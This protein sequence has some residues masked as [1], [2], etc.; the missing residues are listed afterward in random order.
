VKHEPQSAF[1]KSCISQR[2][3]FSRTQLRLSEFN[4][5]RFTPGLGEAPRDDAA[6]LSE[7][8]SFVA[9]A[10]ARIAP[11]LGGLPHDP[12]LFLSWF[13]ELKHSGPGQN[14]LLFP[15]LA[16]KADWDQMRW[17]LA[18]ELAGEAGFDDLVA[19]TQIKMPSRAKLEMARNYWDEMG[20]GTEQGMHGPM[21]S[22]LAACFGIEPVPD[23]TVPESLAL[24]NMMVGLAANRRY[25]FHAV[26][27]L[28]AIELTAPTRAGFVAAGL[29]RL[30]VSAKARNYFALHAVLDVKHA[31]AW[32]REVIFSLVAEDPRRAPA[33]AEGAL[34]RL[35]CGARCFAR[36][37]MQFGR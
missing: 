20:R 7:E 22:R 4:R 8:E 2:T 6:F 10:R 9:S 37:R 32:N 27:A 31:E 11:F 29:K 33:I 1:G 26:G 13:E 5:A 12:H 35:W 3:A 16:D 30:G 21:L 34:L 25:A 18:Q 17:F 14:D 15:W 23:E 28:G 24:G 19:L 36:Y